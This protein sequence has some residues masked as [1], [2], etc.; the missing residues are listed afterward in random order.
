MGNLELLRQ[1]G[2]SQ[3]PADM[4][5]VNVHKM[6]AR[7]KGF[8]QTEKVLQIYVLSLSLVI[9]LCCNHNCQT[10]DINNISLESAA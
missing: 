10:K 6:L 5:G 8:P 1:A 2:Q 4:S 7:R 9:A 3:I